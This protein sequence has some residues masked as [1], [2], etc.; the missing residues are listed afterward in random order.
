MAAGLL[1]GFSSAGCAGSGHGEGRD[2]AHCGGCCPAVFPGRYVCRGLAT[3]WRCIGR[4]LASCVRECV[5][6]VLQ[7][8]PSGLAKPR[9]GSLWFRRCIRVTAAS[10]PA[11]H[12]LAMPLCVLVYHQPTPVVCLYAVV[13]AVCRWCRCLMGVGAACIWGCRDLPDVQCTPCV[14]VCEREAHSWREHVGRSARGCH[15]RLLLGLQL[16]VAASKQAGG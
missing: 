1:T 7:Q 12:L 11:L 14:W 9:L 16:A 2:W 3:A 13:R 5:C 8:S 15:P 4:V 10:L 6:C